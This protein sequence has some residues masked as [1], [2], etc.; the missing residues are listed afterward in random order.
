MKLSALY[1][2]LSGD[3]KAARRLKRKIWFKFYLPAVLL[4]LIFQVIKSLA[5]LKIRD[6]ARKTPF[7]P[8]PSPEKKE[9]SLNP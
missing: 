5:R 6:L 7:S 4:A 8:E 3:P 1:P 2:Y 9:S